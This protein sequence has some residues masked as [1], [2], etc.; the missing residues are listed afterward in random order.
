MMR[1]A[2][3]AVMLVT[4]SAYAQ[5]LIRTQS[6]TTT[7]ETD[8]S[9]STCANDTATFRWLY[10]P[11]G[12][13]PTNSLQLW[14]TTSTTCSTSG[15]A[16]GDLTYAS[17]S[18]II[19]TQVRTGNF[20]VKYSQLPGLNGSALP[21]GGTV[22]SCGATDVETSVRLCGGF[23]STVGVT[24]TYILADPMVIKYD[25]KPPSVPTLTEVDPLESSL[26]VA[27]SGDADTQNIEARYRPSAAL[28]DGGAQDAG[29]TDW[30]SAGTAEF[31]NGF[32]IVT[33]LADGVSY[34]VSIRAFDLAGNGSD[35]SGESSGVPIHTL[36]F[37]GEFNQLGG[38]SGGCS[39]AGS[40]FPAAAGA[41]LLLRSLSTRRKSR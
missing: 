37:W 9:A 26:K 5:L 21:D 7:T 32:I 8:I 14:A 31:V 1:Q 28:A 24:T 35:W 18:T 34:D 19:L 33:G 16:D 15:P 6:D 20:D 2:L 10:T 13:T 36:G 29:A 12:T 25:T 30:V 4:T 40:L 38:E 23:T 17:V 22:I 41:L 27:F 39:S 11:T 3:L